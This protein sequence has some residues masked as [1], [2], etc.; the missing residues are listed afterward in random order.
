MI[1]SYAQPFNEKMS[2]ELVE[3]WEKNK[4]TCERFF[5]TFS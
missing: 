2:K 4:K 1:S 3:I 5:N